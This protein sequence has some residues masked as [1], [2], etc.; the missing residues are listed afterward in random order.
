M[1]TG[2]LV[3]YESRLNDATPVASTTAAGYD[4][5]NLR[6]ARPYTFWKPTAVPATVTVDCGSSK[7][8]DYLAVYGHDLFATGCT[9][10]VRKSTDNF[11]ANDV[12]VN[13]HTPTD[14]EPILR[15]FTSTS[16]RYWRL[17]V[18]TGTAPTL[19][20][21]MLG[22]KIEIP[23][24]VREGFDPVG[25][26]IKAQYNRSNAGHPL[27]KVIQFREWKER[28]VFELVSWTWARDT[29]KAAA[30]AWLESEP[31]LFSWNADTYPKETYLVSMD[32]QWA[33]PHRSGQICDL[34]VPVTG[35]MP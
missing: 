20:I 3:L 13:T 4:V 32:G 8:A 33:T 19:A 10:E 17:R 30:E 26:V 5:L 34:E 23:A 11:A 9:I 22:V 1:A 14:D 21:A 16:S 27:G 7:S 25:R 12:L 6:D 18:L 15:L 28:L 2:P 31:W 35:V 29:W 24:G